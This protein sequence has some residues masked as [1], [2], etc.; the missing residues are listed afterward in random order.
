M[1]TS[2]PEIQVFE[3]GAN[4]LKVQWEELPP[5]KAR[6]IIANYQI[7]YRKH[8]QETPDV[9]TVDGPTNQYTINGN[10]CLCIVGYQLS[11]IMHN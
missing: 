10:G 4:A 5:D 7:F 6:G 11:A 9:S 1:P 2:A 8:G 3:A